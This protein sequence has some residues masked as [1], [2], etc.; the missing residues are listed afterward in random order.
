[1]RRKTVMALAVGLVLITAGC[2]GSTNADGN[3]TTTN[4]DTSGHQT[5]P[6]TT[7]EAAFKAPDGRATIA[8]SDNDTMA[9][10][11]TALA[12]ETTF[13]V[14]RTLQMQSNWSDAK[15]SSIHETLTG[16]YNLS[17]GEPHFN[18]TQTRTVD[19]AS[20][21]YLATY[22]GEYIHNAWA[23]AKS[24]IPDN[25]Q[26][27]TNR[28]GIDGDIDGLNLAVGPGMGLSAVG[29]HPLETLTYEAVGQTTHDGTTVI[30]YEATNTSALEGKYV[31]KTSETEV[32]LD[33][34]RMNGRHFGHGAQIES[35]NAT[36]LVDDRGI[37][38]KA[39]YDITISTDGELTTYSF[40]AEYTAIGDSV[41]ISQ[42]E[43]VNK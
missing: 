41:T 16:T 15:Q 37:I 29:F 32:I 4:V 20:G 36:M 24:D 27:V 31:R 17:D 11:E 3:A 2:T 33:L 42:P 9:T 10:H 7:T 6:A 34:G 13:A 35:V 18:A 14:R 43:W 25:A 1:M 26:T 8:P 28:R 23:T 12:D 39:T 5:T 22:A 38:H 40:A 30:A 19:G 21:R